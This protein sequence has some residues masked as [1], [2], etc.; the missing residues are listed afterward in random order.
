M[1]RV[2]HLWRGLGE[3]GRVRLHGPPP[4]EPR[5]PTVAFTIDDIPSEE[6]C[7]R[8][9]DRG[10]FASHGDSYASTVV[11][12]PGRSRGGLVRIGLACY[13]I[14]EEIDRLLDAVREVVR[15]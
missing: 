15:G 3:I 7:R 11:E 9:A 13:T 10:P 6:V 8:L 1:A 5:T 4:S 2:E 12:R 14:G